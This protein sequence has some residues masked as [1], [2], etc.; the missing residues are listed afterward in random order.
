MRISYFWKWQGKPPKKQ[1]FF[2]VAEPLK[3]L[4]KKG[5][6][7]KKARNSLE[8]KKVRVARL[9]NE[10][11]TKDFF[12]GLRIFSRKMLRNS[13]RN[14]WSLISW[15]RKIPQNSR[16]ISRQISLPKIKKNPLTSF[17]RS[18]RR[19]KSKEIQKSKEKKIRVWAISKLWI[20]GVNSANTL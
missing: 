11:G 7:R 20:S 17:C 8:R 10:V 3:S 1:G 2:I 15:V 16:Q 12:G 13:P 14:F 5:K 18:A 4:G 6:T 9:Q 19:K